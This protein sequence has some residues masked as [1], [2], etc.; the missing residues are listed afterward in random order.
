MDQVLLQ[1]SSDAMKQAVEMW[2]A[3]KAVQL[4]PLF[5]TAAIETSRASKRS[6]H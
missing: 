1:V 3:L 2:Q 5:E 4:K 6:R